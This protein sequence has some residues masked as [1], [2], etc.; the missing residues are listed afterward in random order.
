MIHHFGL[1]QF[2]VVATDNLHKA[3][4][5]FGIGTETGEESF[6]HNGFNYSIRFEMNVDKK[7]LKIVLTLKRE[8]QELS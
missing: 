7:S 4:G 6:D 8:W 1:S 5:P 3:E 2:P